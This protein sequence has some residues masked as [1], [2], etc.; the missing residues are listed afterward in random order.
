MEKQGSKHS[1]N[2]ENWNITGSSQT[3]EAEKRREVFDVGRRQEANILLE[4]QIV[5]SSASSCR[6]DTI[7]EFYEPYSEV[8]IKMINFTGRCVWKK[9][10]PVHSIFLKKVKIFRYVRRGGQ[11][12][13]WRG[14]NP[15]ICKKQSGKGKYLELGSFK[16]STSD[17]HSRSLCRACTMLVMFGHCFQIQLW[18]RKKEEPEIIRDERSHR[19]PRKFCFNR[20]RFTWSKA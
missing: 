5:K 18:Q 20:K 7:V 6:V 1:R 8:I 15:K 16:R 19:R 11:K 12:F 9:F 3:N 14:W 13:S 17:P 2:T 10:R 4:D